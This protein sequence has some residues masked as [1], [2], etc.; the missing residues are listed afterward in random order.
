L[1][2]TGGNSLA[3]SFSPDNQWVAYTSYEHNPGISWA[4]EIYIRRV[5]GSETRRLTFNE[6]CDWQPRWGP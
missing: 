2:T 1:L 6:Y 4:C 5:D 3:P